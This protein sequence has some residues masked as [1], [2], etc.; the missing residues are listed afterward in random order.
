MS[1][2]ITIARTVATAAAVTALVGAGQAF[3]GTGEAL[4][5]RYENAA[6][7]YSGGANG[8]VAIAD[9]AGDSM[10]VYT[11]YDRYYNSGLRLDNSGGVGTTKYSGSDTVNYVSK[12]TACLNI[13]LNPD[14]C[15]PDD[16]PGDGR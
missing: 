3:A 8:V 2:G 5:S 13:Q 14:R 10:S 15:G 6:Y 16:R 4:E 12:V 9:T 11:L 7:A 1:F